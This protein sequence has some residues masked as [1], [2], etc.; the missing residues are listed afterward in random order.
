MINW[1][2]DY[3]PSLDR[4]VRMTAA[5]P[6][7]AQSVGD[8]QPF[9]ARNDDADDGALENPN[10]NDDEVND[11]ASDNNNSNSNSNNDDNHSNEQNNNNNSD[12]GGE[13][14]NRSAHSRRPSSMLVVAP[15]EWP[16]T[17]QLT[18]NTHNSISSKQRDIYYIFEYVEDCYTFLVNSLVWLNR[19]CEIDAASSDECCS[20]VDQRCYSRTS[21]NTR[22]PTSRSNCR[23]IEMRLI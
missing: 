7:A 22:R 15:R 2:G 14:A 10:G 6:T 8:E 20:M 16:V 19:A 1:Q 3:Q 21:V 23:R 18:C 4:D 11:K 13:I 5:P 12:N 9:N 17:L